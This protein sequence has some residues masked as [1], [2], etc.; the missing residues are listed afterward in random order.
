[1]TIV[2][3][4]PS[5]YQVKKKLHNALNYNLWG[6]NSSVG[7]DLSVLFEGNLLKIFFELIKFQ[8]I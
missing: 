6:F 3:V 4:S 8:F 1:M 7:T 2:Q 5:W